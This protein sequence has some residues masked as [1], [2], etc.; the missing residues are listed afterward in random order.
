[1]KRKTALILSSL[2]LLGGVAIT[3]PLIV[4]CSTTYP[5][6]EKF[7]YELRVWD[8]NIG[9]FDEPSL[10]YSYE[11]FKIKWNGSLESTLYDTNLIFDYFVKTLT[12]WFNEKQLK[13]NEVRVINE[14]DN[15]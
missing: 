4:S 12:D 5:I 1:M 3:T 8:I 14:I 10:V 6:K 11:I 13:D 2:A 9:T 15:K 7:K